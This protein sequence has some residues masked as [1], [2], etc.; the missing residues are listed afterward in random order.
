MRKLRILLAVVS[1][2]VLASCSAFQGEMDRKFGDQAFKTTIALVELHKV[3][4]GQYPEK[5]TDIRFAGDWDPIH[6]N[7]VEY[8]RL[9]NGY[10]LNIVR[11]WMGKPDLSYPPE[12]WQGLGIVKSNVRRE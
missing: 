10:E 5:L 9:P 3:R 4:F 1:V 2:A 6:L 8:K 12:F 11:G 7:S